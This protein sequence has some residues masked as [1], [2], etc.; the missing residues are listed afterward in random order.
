MTFC[1]WFLLLNI[2]FSRL[3]YV[4]VCISTLLLQMA[5]L[6]SI[7]ETDH[8]LFSHLSVEGH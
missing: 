5:E 3:I 2:M 8:I 4:A 6:H 7:A 1:V